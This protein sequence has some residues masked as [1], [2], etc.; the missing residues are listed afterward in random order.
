MDHNL[1]LL[2]SASHAPMQKIMDI[3]DDLDLLP[4][5]TCPTR[6]TQRSATLIDNILISE[7]LHKTYELAVILNDI[8]T[9]YQ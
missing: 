1:D 7:Q 3:V 4:T 5:I 9:I 6:I 2:K 8:L